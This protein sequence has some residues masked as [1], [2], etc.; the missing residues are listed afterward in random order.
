[1]TQANQ[2]FDPAIAQARFIASQITGV[3]GEQLQ[4]N[5][6]TAFASMTFKLDPNAQLA[7]L[8]R[9]VRDESLGKLFADGAVFEAIGD[10]RVVEVVFHKLE[11][12]SGVSVATAVTGNDAMARLLEKARL[13]DLDLT[14]RFPAEKVQA[15]DQVA[16][17]EIN[18]QNM[19]VAVKQAEPKA[20]ERRHFHPSQMA[21]HIAVNPG[22]RLAFKELLVNTWAKDRNAL[23]MPDAEDL[24]V[25][26]VLWVANSHP[27]DAAWFEGVT[28]FDAAGEPIASPKAATALF[29][30][31]LEGREGPVIERD[32][33]IERFRAARA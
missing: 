9:L 25:A 8:E 11:D 27:D 30:A 12:G 26:T 23:P 21:G 14:P 31:A 29:A 15:A 33:L 10:E 2:F 3:D 20:S 5:G 22:N 19:Q 18:G 7:I 16:T 17:L 4:A 24:I 1:M 6:G 32:A 13:E 28:A